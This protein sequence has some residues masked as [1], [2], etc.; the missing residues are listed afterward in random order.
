M[1]MRNAGFTLLE[2]LIALFIFTILSTILVGALRNMMDAQTA[3][4]HK[5]E[6]L[7]HLQFA[8]LMISRDVEQAIDRPVYAADGK[9][10]QSFIGASKSFT[11]THAGYANLTGVLTH[12]TLQRT[13]YYWDN[14]ALWRKS[15][16]VLDQ[17]PQTQAHV[18][19]LLEDVSEAHF[20][21]LDKDNKFHD[22]WPVEGQ[23]EQQLP[24]AVRIYLT[25]SKWGT[26]SQLYVIAAQPAKTPPT[27]SP[28]EPEKS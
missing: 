17:A 20:Q 16:G 14:G 12:S 15:W 11:F 27:T 8:L 7:R 10:E 9:E 3:T 2:I 19:D 6:R 5:A 28:Q 1:K 4:E 23:D 25:I 18:R 24:R 26:M 13:G 21:Y 22:D